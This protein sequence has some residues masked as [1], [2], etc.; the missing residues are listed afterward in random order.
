ML[1]ETGYPIDLR[2]LNIQLL[3]VTI[4][5]MHYGAGTLVNS[6][7]LRE[8]SEKIGGDYVVLPSSIH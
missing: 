8:V 4:D 3:V 1:E 6:E 2:E 5:S 7:V